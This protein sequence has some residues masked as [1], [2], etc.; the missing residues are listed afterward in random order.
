MRVK[1][2]VNSPVAL[3]DHY[4]VRLLYDLGSHGIAIVIIQ[5]PTCE[6]WA[7]KIPVEYE[8]QFATYMATHGAGIYI[9]PLRDQ[10]FPVTP[11]TD[12]GSGT[13]LEKGA[14]A[15]SFSVDKQLGFEMERN[16]MRSLGLAKSI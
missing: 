11:I 8:N 6:S 5:T 13:H 16:T 2:I 10:L 14:E 4:F 7:D 12:F 9:T 1:S 15:F 3:I